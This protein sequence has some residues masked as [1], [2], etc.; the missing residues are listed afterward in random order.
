VDA[1]RIDERDV[2]VR[3]SYDE[4]LVLAELLFRWSD[5]GDRAAFRLDNA[6]E[7]RLLDDLCASLEPIIDEGVLRRLRP[8]AGRGPPSRLA[9][10][11]RLSDL[12]A[13]GQAPRAS[14]GG[15]RTVG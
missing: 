7:G 13:P 3:F 2:T 10:G 9:H 15:G 8:G 4:A 14:A 1:E 11:G 6:A 5:A 12:L